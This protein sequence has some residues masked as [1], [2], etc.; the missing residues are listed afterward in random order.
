[1]SEG[2]EV[3]PKSGAVKEA[4]PALALFVSRD[5]HIEFLALSHLLLRECEVP[6][7]KLAHPLTQAARVSENGGRP[8]VRLAL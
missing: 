6:F 4:N 8:P 7:R 2:Q 3:A 1:L 5:Q